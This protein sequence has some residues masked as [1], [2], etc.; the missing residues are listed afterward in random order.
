ME[1]CFEVWGDSENRRDKKIQ[2]LRKRT[3]QQCSC[4]KDNRKPETIIYEWMRNYI[5]MHFYALLC[6]GSQHLPC[7]VHCAVFS[8]IPAFHYSVLRVYFGVSWPYGEPMRA[9]LVIVKRRPNFSQYRYRKSHC[10][11]TRGRIFNRS[12]HLSKMFPMYFKLKTDVVSHNQWQSLRKEQLVGRD[13]VNV[14]HRAIHSES[15]RFH[16]AI[17]HHLQL[18]ELSPPESVWLSSAHSFIFFSPPI[19]VVIC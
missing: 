12:L 6:I 17:F 11:F 2:I 9:T 8:W 13:S 10:G 3:R 18:S 7:T 5:S 1:R 19:S 4:E 16:S 14:V 15:S